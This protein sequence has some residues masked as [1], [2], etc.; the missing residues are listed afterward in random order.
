MKGFRVFLPET[1]EENGKEG[2]DGK[3]ISKSPKQVRPERSLREK[4]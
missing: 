2:T 4:Y 3:K 1:D